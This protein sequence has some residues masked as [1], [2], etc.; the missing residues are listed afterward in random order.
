MRLTVSTTGVGPNAAGNP[1]ECHQAQDIEL[2]RFFEPNA[3]V[4][5]IDL[6]P[7]EA[8]GVAVD[9]LYQLVDAGVIAGW[10]AQFPERD[11]VVA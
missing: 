11:D 6:T 3:D 8:L 4:A 2:R 9:L 5:I 1:S 7:T 10:S